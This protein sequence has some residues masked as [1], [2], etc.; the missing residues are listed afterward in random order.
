MIVVTPPQAAAS[1]P[2][3]KSSAVYGPSARNWASRWVCGSTTPGST[4]RPVA[5]SSTSA[6]PTSPIA[7]IRPSAMPMS[8]RRVSVAVTIVP[9]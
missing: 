4:S 1:V 5:S 3:R 9:P 7:T 6:S 2:E 8:A